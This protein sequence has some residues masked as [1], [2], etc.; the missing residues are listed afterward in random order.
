[1]HEIMRRLKLTVNEAMTRVCH[2]PEE[3]FDFLGDRFGH[4][5]RHK[6][7]GRTCYHLRELISLANSTHIFRHSVWYITRASTKP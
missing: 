7:D 3:R 6:L 2:L 1:M 4:T 5:T